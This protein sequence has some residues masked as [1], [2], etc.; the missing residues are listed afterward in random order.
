M[1]EVKNLNKESLGLKDISFRLYRQRDLGSGW[2]SREQAGQSWL[3]V[4]SDF[5]RPTAEP[6]KWRKAVTI[7]N[8]RAAIE[9]GLGYLTEDRR[10]L[11]IFS[12]MNIWQNATAVIVD[13]LTKPGGCWTAKRLM[14][15]HPAR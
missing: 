10:H 6:L 9:A 13:Q 15:W 5:I 4:S 14:K 1:L 11:G 12:D 7:R 3:P 2:D 8:P